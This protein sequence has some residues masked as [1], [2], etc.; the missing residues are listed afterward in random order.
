MHDRDL[1]MDVVRRVLDFEAG[2]TSELADSVFRNPV[3][4]YVDEGL[5]RAELE[6]LFRRWPLCAGLSCELSAPG[7]YKTFDLPGVPVV[8]VRGQ[9]GEL[10]AFLNVCR[11]RGARLVDGRGHAR[12]I[13]CPFH[14]WTFG[15]DGQ[16]MGIPFEQGFC[17]DGS[18][19]DRSELALAPLPVAERHGLMFVMP[20]DGTIDIEDHLNTLDGELAHLGLADLHYFATRDIE[21]EMNW[22]VAMDT[23]TEAYHFPFL[24][25]ASVGT[26]AMGNVHTQDSH[27]PHQRIAFAAKTLLALRDAPEETW[28]P[29]N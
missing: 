6:V 11:H 9:G 10:R 14:A 8:L 26:V 15:T 7:D 18:V 13:T 23:Y 1:L 28:D 12:R 21:T 3:A 4:R 29:A 20:S 2:G 25:K 17:A 24:H 16:L 27:G 19:L 5:W 22:H